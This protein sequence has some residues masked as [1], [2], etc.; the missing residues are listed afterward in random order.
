MYIERKAYREKQ[1]ELLDF[2]KRYTLLILIFC[3][4]FGSLSGVGIWYSATVASPRGISAL[5]HN[6]VWGWATEW[7]FFLIE[8]ATIYVY[9]YTFGKVDEKTHLRIGYLYALAAWISMIII[10]GILAFM[11]TPG[12]WLETGRFFDGFFNSTYWPQLFARTFLMFGIAAVYALVVATTLQNKAVQYKITRLA[13]LWGILGFLIGG[14]MTYW[15]LKKLPEPAQDFLFGGTLPYLKTLLYVSGISWVL[16]LLYFLLC[17]ALFPRAN[18]L[19]GSLLLM[20][21]LFFGIFAGEGLR[22]GLRRPYI[23]NFFMY[24]HQVVA[25]DLPAKGIQAET[26]LL[27]EAGYLSRLGYLPPE[28]RKITPENQVEIGRILV[29][30]QCANCHALSAK[31][32]RSLPKLLSGMGMTDPEDLAGFL[33]G[34]DGYPYMPPFVGTE[35]ERLAAGAY[36]STLVENK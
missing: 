7:V 16:A 13:G 8:V 14:L 23:V 9:Y 6:Y 17:G 1:L 36:L 35:E 10:T 15:Y 30:H 21:I 18:T 29:I 4:V 22:E 24:S 5:I 26:E 11:L 19:A 27:S 33:E 12:K 31:G 25:A 20:L 3:F 32:L 2:I 28:L 34:L